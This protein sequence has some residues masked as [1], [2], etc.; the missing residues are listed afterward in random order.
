MAEFCEMVLSQVSRNALLLSAAV[1]FGLIA[2]PLVKARPTTRVV[3]WIL[4]LLPG[5]I[6]ISFVVEIPWYE[7]SSIVNT[8]VEAVTDFHHTEALTPP[9]ST[10]SNEVVSKSSTVFH[11]ASVGV[12]AVWVGG[13]LF[14][15]GTYFKSYRSLKVA[16]AGFASVESKDVHDVLDPASVSMEIVNSWRKEMASVAKE[17]GLAKVPD[18]RLC[19]SLGPLLSYLSG[20]YVVFVP[21]EFWSQCESCERVSILRHELSHVKRG[22]LWMA[23]S[24]RL[25]ML[26]QWFNPLAWLALRELDQAIEMACD[27]HV[28]EQ[29]DVCPI[30][31]AKSL[32]SFVEFKR[33]QFGFALSASRPPLHQRIVNSK[34]IEMSFARLLIIL[35]LVCIST[36]ALM[37]PKLVAQE[38]TSVAPVAQMPS[39]Q[40]EL[41]PDVAAAGA[42]EEES[43][44]LIT[45]TYYVGDLIVP[46]SPASAQA[47]LQKALEGQL[48]AADH[49][50]TDRDLKPLED[51][52]KKTICPDKWLA[53]GRNLTRDAQSLSLV[54][55]NVPL[56]HEMIA[57]LLSQLR[58]MNLVTIET[59]A[60]TVV[61]PK[62]GDWKSTKRPDVGNA[63]RPEEVKEIRQHA[64]SNSWA[65]RELPET[66]IYNGQMVSH[67]PGMVGARKLAPLTMSVVTNSTVNSVRLVWNVRQRAQ[68][69]PMSTGK[70]TK[71]LDWALP[72][73]SAMI[74]HEQFAVFDVSNSSKDGASKESVFLFVQLLIHDNREN[75]P[76][77]FDFPVAQNGNG[78]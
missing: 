33:S 14:T 28:L 67:E 1:L 27:D 62:G 17:L 78:R 69:E 36:F 46:T 13:M 40:L 11:Y 35:G 2:L 37:R 77:A 29:T 8:K 38:S 12:L 61:V 6:L 41:Q 45:K 59:K 52:I 23:F 5:W 70:E 74:P 24:A 44:R 76:G 25:M 22:D 20:R 43:N 49:G 73:A 30:E 4:A 71:Q 34:G 42:N 48:S 21:S 32:M 72:V 57:N 26:P 39:K 55:D 50:I 16:V 7:A 19:D 54:I 68:V 60:F 63:M 47:H 3:V 66:H 9:V 56:Q 15:F 58:E 31:Y 51:L 65:V 10:S 75:L 64:E 18:L 53:E